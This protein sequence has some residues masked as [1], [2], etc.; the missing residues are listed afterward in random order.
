M[1]VIASVK[2]NIIIHL[3]PRV[4]IIYVAI[5]ILLCFGTNS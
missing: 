1:L 5:I 4:I 3:H 2:V